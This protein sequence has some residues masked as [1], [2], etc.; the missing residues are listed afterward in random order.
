MAFTVTV[1]DI[2]LSFASRTV[3]N[4]S[5]SARSSGFSKVTFKVLPVSAGS[6]SFHLFGSTGASSG[7]V[8]ENAFVSEALSG[9]PVSSSQALSM[10]SVYFFP[11]SKIGPSSSRGFNPRFTRPG[12]KSTVNRLPSGLQ[13]SSSSSR[14]GR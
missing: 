1:T 4:R 11:S 7:L 8:T 12:S 5:A 9:K 13:S 10:T 14:N 3:S 2:G 6:M